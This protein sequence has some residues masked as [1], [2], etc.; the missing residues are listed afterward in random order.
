MKF[1]ILMIGLGLIAG[2]S[3]RATVTPPSELPSRALQQA[4]RV[5]A[6]ENG[7][8]LPSRAVWLGQRVARNSEKLKEDESKKTA[9]K[10]LKRAKTSQQN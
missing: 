8:D 5:A 4:R 2:A 9:R 6:M 10:V 7:Q 3:A 1:G